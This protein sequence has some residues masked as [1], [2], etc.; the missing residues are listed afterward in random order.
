M[1]FITS[2]VEDASGVVVDVGVGVGVGVGVDGGVAGGTVLAGNLPS[3]D[4]ANRL[5]SN[6]FSYQGIN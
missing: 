3:G 5:N 4:H 2:Y 6:L 1:N